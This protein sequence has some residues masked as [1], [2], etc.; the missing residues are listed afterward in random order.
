M[1]NDPENHCQGKPDSD[2]VLHGRESGTDEVG[3]HPVV[4]AD[5]PIAALEAVRAE[6]SVETSSEENQ[7]EDQPAGAVEGD[8]FHR[9]TTG[10]RSIS[11]VVGHLARVL[12][13][14]RL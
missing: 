3:A 2:H 6:E 9:F 11:L 8:E 4:R 1:V 7:Q 10:Y 14:R 5:E 12:L 13:G